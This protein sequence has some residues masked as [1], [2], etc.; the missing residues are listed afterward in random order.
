[1]A[2]EEEGKSAAA[3]DARVGDA[4]CQEYVRLWA[5][6]FAQV[7]TQITGAPVAC[8]MLPQAPAGLKP[9]AEDDQ[10]V[11]VTAVGGVRGEMSVR[12]GAAS[13]LRLG[14]AFMSEP[15]APD[16]PLTPDHRES[17]IELL[18]Q[19]SGIVA[20]GAKARWGEVQLHLEGVAAAPSWT[21]AESFR[22]EAGEET[23]PS[24]ALEFG[25]SAALV[26]EL[27][28]VK[29]EPAKEEAAKPAV[30][31]STPA[32]NA[33]S[34]AEAGPLDL[35][36]DVQLAV[37]MRFGS[38]RLLLREVLDLS[39]GAVI[40][41]DRRVREPVDLLLDGRLVAR[42]EVVV[43]DGNYGLRVSEVSPQALPAGRRD[44]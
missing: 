30:D 7:I 10:W 8:R 40:E 4:R 44:G 35:L 41:L 13:V 18:R 9:A 16:V 32:A 24:M 12:L 15:A 26:A 20:S 14:Q 11:M 6:S 28:A 42:G 38:R 5:D 19:V 21:A 37:S 31:S 36:M 27:R 25:L 43:I 1:M 17:V 39:P 33:A 34:T 23:P 29:T 2:E 3:G 22:L